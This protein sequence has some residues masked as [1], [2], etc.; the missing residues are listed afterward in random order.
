M[1]SCIRLY[2]FDANDP[3]GTTALASK[4]KSRL[5]L[6]LTKNTICTSAIFK[7]L[8]GT[9]PHPKA[10]FSNNRA[11]PPPQTVTAFQ[12]PGLDVGH[13]VVQRWVEQESQMRAWEPPSAQHARRV[14]PAR[15]WGT[16]SSYY[17]CHPQTAGGA[18]PARHGHLY[19]WRSA[20][21]LPC[22]HF[23]TSCYSSVGRVPSNV[24]L[25]P[26]QVC[27]ARHAEQLVV[28]AGLCHSSFVQV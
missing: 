18:L 12:Q 21:T 17:S 9:W 23:E 7:L 15:R 14:C 10:L 8:D 16:Q 20:E 11:Q 22:V 13:R 19:S 1:S 28:L 26:R 2:L 4:I 3:H 5:L 25:W 24:Q 27:R 6:C